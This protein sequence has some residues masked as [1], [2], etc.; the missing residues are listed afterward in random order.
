MREQGLELIHDVLIQ[1]ADGLSADRF[2]SAYAQM[3]EADARTHIGFVLCR[4]GSSAP[5]QA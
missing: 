5:R 4:N 2:S 1:R 3:S